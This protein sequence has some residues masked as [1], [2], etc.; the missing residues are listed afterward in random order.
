MGSVKNAANKD[1]G[2]GKDE[3]NDEDHRHSEGQLTPHFAQRHSVVVGDP[4][5]YRNIALPRLL[6]PHF[7]DALKSVPENI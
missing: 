1:A 4:A 3:H 7:L 2:G 5:R 6:F